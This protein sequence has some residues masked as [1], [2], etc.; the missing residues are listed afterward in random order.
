MKYVINYRL[1]LFSDPSHLIYRCKSIHLI[2]CSSRKFD[3]FVL[4]IKKGN[5]NLTQNQ[6]NPMRHATLLG[7][8]S[9]D[10]GCVTIKFALYPIR[11]CNILTISLHQLL[12]D[13]QF[14]ILLLHTLLAT[15]DPHPFTP[16]NNV[17]PLKSFTHPLVRLGDLEICSVV[18][19]KG[20][21]WNTKDV[22]RETRD[23]RS[24]V[25]RNRRRTEL[26]R[27][28]HGRQSRVAVSPVPK[29]HF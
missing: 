6:R 18:K 4:V 23:V 27:E 9:K 19:H 21:G 3:R 26:R 20:S 15:T 8:R 29:F 7:E 28:K 16:E 10:F 14:S 2:A 17:I 25:G 1:R 22:W 12:I 5:S 13:C 24:S 11:I